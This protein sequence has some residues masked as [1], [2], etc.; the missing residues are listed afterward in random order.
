MEV[1]LAVITI[2][3]LAKNV[4]KT[5]EEIK[6][7]IGRVGQSISSGENVLTILAYKKQEKASRTY[8]LH[9]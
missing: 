1:A 8:R 7:F 9:R 3:T 2:T 6:D 5:W 4:V